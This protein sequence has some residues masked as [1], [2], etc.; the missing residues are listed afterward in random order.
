VLCSVCDLGF[1]I[2][3]SWSPSSLAIC[4]ASFFI[5]FTLLLKISFSIGPSLASLPEIMCLSTLI[6]SPHTHAYNIN[7]F[8]LFS[9]LFFSFPGLEVVSLCSVIWEFLYITCLFW[10]LLWYNLISSF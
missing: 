5:Y 1:A 2:L 6:P 10:L 4:I 9:V 8:C 7:T 3:S